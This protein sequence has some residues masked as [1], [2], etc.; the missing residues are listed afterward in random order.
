MKFWIMC[1][2]CVNLFSVGKWKKERKFWRELISLYRSVCMCFGI[3]LLV[4]DCI[5][6]W[7]ICGG[8]FVV[9][10]LG[11]LEDLLFVGWL[12]V[13]GFGEYGK[14]GGKLKSIKEKY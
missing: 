7:E 4:I 5:N 13:G 8:L 1:L 12:I 11:L 9:C 3:C 2:I 10:C 14:R 6:N